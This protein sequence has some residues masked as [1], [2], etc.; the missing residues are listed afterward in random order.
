MP[1]P[2]KFSEVMRARCEEVARQRATMP[3][4]KALAQ[5]LDVPV[6]AIHYLMSQY[7]K[8]TKELGST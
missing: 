3:S 5:E 4:D 7:R 2:K 1:A 6:R 8:L